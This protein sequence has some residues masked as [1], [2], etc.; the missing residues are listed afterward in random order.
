VWR[1]PV[2]ADG[3]SGRINVNALGVGLNYSAESEIPS[4]LRAEFLV[5][6]RRTRITAPFTAFEVDGRY[7]NPA[8]GQHR[9]QFSQ[10]SSSGTALPYSYLSYGASSSSGRG[11]LFGNGSGFKFE[12]GNMLV[13]DD[14]LNSF[15]PI[16]ATDFVVSSSREV[17]R[18][19]RPATDKIDVKKLFRDVQAVTYNYHDDQPEQGPRF[20]VIAEELPA[21]LQRITPDGKGGTELSVDLAS[22]VGLLWAAVNTMWAALNQLLDQ[23]GGPRK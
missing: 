4:R 16:K 23:Q 5:T 9:V 17:K 13:T 8:G 7:D 18:N 11:G 12:A 22:Q 15:G 2:A 14:S 19:V 6:D 3:R 20:G 10:L 21:V 1:G